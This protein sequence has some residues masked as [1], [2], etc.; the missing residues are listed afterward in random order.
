MVFE[1]DHDPDEAGMWRV[2]GVEPSSYWDVF[3]PEAFPAWDDHERVEVEDV[4]GCR[5]L[6][7]CSVECVSFQH[8]TIPAMM[9]AMVADAYH[10]HQN[11]SLSSWDR[12]QT[13]NT[14]QRMDRKMLRIIERSQSWYL[15]LR[16]RLPR[17]WGTLSA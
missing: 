3:E 14:V 2:F 13:A 7:E 10:I 5:L 8:H 1:R 15:L 9:T 16:D 4:I 11:G 6:V 17:I 12:H